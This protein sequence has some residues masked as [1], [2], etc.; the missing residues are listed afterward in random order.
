MIRVSLIALMLVGCATTDTK[1]TYNG[2]PT[3]P[4][5]TI[6]LAGGNTLVHQADRPC[7][8]NDRP[9][10]DG[11]ERTYSMWSL[12]APND[13]ILVNAPSFLTDPTYAGQFEEYYRRDDLVQVF[14]SGSGNTV[15]ILEDRSPTFPNR[16]HFILRRD[17]QG[18]WSCREVLLE[19]YLPK[20]NKGVASPSPQSPLDEVY[21][22]ILE[23]TDSYLRYSASTGA[24]TVALNALRTRG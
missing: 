20:E 9:A 18:H 6:H 10:V 2:A 7:M 14:E 19:S 12:N 5:T 1:P 24:K 21:P 13:Q 17:A 16:A 15:L 3:Y 8:T 4:R 22:E 11:G 23:V